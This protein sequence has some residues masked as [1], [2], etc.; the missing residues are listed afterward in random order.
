VGQGSRRLSVWALQADG[1]WRAESLAGIDNPFGALRG[2]WVLSSTEAVA[3]GESGMALRKSD[4]VWRQVDSNTQ[5]TLTAVRAFTSGH[6]YV[7]QSDGR[8]RRYANSTWT[9]V[10]RNDAGVAFN[11]ITGMNEEDLWAV[12]VNGVIGR[13]PH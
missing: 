5:A 8:V 11:D 7:S 12:G 2:V 3:V 6:F 9:T 4:G 13:S 1:T 10:F